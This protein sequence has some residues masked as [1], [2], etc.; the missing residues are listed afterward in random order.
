M[1]SIN[2]LLISSFKTFDQYHLLW[3][4]LLG[5]LGYLMYRQYFRFSKYQK[6]KFLKFLAWL[7][8][9]L[10]VIKDLVL[11]WEGKF[12]VGDLPFHLCGISIF[13]C[14]YES[15]RHTEFSK[16]LVYTLTLSGALLALLFPSW[17]N[18]APFGLRSAQSFIIHFALVLYAVLVFKDKSFKL[19]YYNMF[20]MML[21]VGLL[22]ILIHYFNLAF[23][24]NFMF[25]ETYSA[26]SPLEYLALILPFVPYFFKMIGLM[27]IGI[28]LMYLPLILRHKK[29]R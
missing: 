8:V 12:I 18:I 11:L 16:E 28:L 25:L 4:M 1:L 17:T 29:R 21:F 9:L 14:L 23:A 26:N 27:F 20:K 7:I 5:L 22:A 3:L 19:H 15:Y 6:R 13:L 2:F 10:E 24:T